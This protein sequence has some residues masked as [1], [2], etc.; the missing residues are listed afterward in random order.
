[1]IQIKNFIYRFT[2]EERRVF[3]TFTLE[4]LNVL[5]DLTRIRLVVEDG[6]ITGLEM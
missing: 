5:F 1:M 3:N 6:Q 2:D 4:Q